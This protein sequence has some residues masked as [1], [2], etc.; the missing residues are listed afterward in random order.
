M[1]SAPQASAAS[2]VI[3]PAIQPIRLPAGR[4]ILCVIVDAEEDFHWE[5]PVSARNNATSSIRHQDRAQAVFAK[6]GVRPTYLV[7]YPIASDPAA[8]GVLRDYLQDGRCDIGAQLHP[9]VTPPFDG[10]P[11]ERLSYPGNL[12]PELEREKLRRLVGTVRD[13]F[14]VQPTA[15]KAGRYGLGP[16]TADLLE[17]EGFLVDTSLIPRTRYTDSG[18][19]D[20]AAYDYGPF[21]FG[22]KRRI[23][24]LPVT[25]ALTGL[26]A[27]CAPSV[28]GIAE[29]KPLRRFRVPGMLARAG[30]LERITLSPE[31]SDLRAMLRLTRALLA[32]GERIFTLS[33]HSPSLEPGNTP[34]VRDHRDLAVFLDRLSGFLSFFRDELGGTCMTVKELHDSLAAGQLANDRSRPVPRDTGPVIGP[35]RCLVVANT[36]PPVHGGS[37]IVYDSLARF[38]GGR[39]SVLAPKE[40]Y[41]SGWPIQG[42]RE[43][44]RR[45]PF[46]V[47][48]I[49]SLRTRFLPEDAGPLQRL[50]GLAA[51]LSIRMS[52]L[53]AIRRIARQEN[54]GVVCIGELVAS[55]WL[56]E[57]CHRIFG[58]KTLIY[59]HGEEIST[60]TAYDFSGQRRRRAL[61]AADGI[62]AVSRFTRDTLVGGFGVPAAKIELV[63]NGVDLARFVPKPRPGHLVAR[64]GLA[65]RPVLLTVSRLY[66]R[67]GVDRV[68]ESLP[69]IL[70]EV[71][72][73]IY[74]IVG[75]GSYRPVLEERVAAL[76]LA[77]HVVFTGA[78]PDHELTD[79]YSLGDA[80][81]MANREMPDGET[82]GFGLV[83]L[84]ANAC[85][86]PVIAGKAGGSVDAVTDMVNGLVV[87]GEDTTAISAAVIRLFRDDGLR[88]R[89]RVTGAEVAAVS[90]WDRRVEQFLRFCDALTARA[91]ARSR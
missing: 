55:G 59:I 68:I 67:K 21:W 75:E 27:T 53:R 57:A 12:A 89:L 18:G 36:F 34:Y 62:I 66:A 28:Y 3:F 85:G 4:P 58:L 31:G 43:F 2:E 25:R 77:R 90:G 52:V 38:G 80:F 91:S 79:H 26:L 16:A 20:Y 32:R 42:W 29:R 51:D 70:G 17:D 83:F 88:H 61:A 48:R 50:Y 82:E 7:T 13:S 72:D 10:D 60:R 41:R 49:R 44:D 11:E 15:Y 74:L 78:V 23:L 40:D 30:L 63:S 8:V 84:E 87:D 56:A 14:G 47:H 22:N 19:P 5:R 33:Y 6:Y 64:Y 81:I 46:R 37:A 86:L 76:G 65:G 9:W 69:A 54:I 35:D 1:P 45:A 73:L 24:E 71:P 39:V